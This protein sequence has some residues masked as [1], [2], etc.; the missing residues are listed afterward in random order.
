MNTYM[1]HRQRAAAKRRKL[2]NAFAFFCVALD[3]E[4]I[5]PFVVCPHAAEGFFVFAVNG[6][7]SGKRRRR[8]GLAP[9]A[10]LSSS[11]LLESFVSFSALSSG[12]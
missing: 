12:G 3:M 7:R 2:Y 8:R 1:T 5:F 6:K 4:V 11:E 10:Y 9:G